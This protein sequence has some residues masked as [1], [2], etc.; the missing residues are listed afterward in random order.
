MRPVPLPSEPSRRACAAPYLIA[1]S[2]AAAWVLGGVAVGGLGYSVYDAAVNQ[3]D[4]W[5]ATYRAL[6]AAAITVG[7]SRTTAINQAY[8]AMAAAA[9]RQ[10]APYLI[11]SEMRLQALLF[12]HRPGST[13]PSGPPA[14]IASAAKSAPL[15]LPAP[16]VVPNASGVIRSFVQESDQVYYRVFSGSQQG[17]FLTSVPPRSSAFAR[18]ALALPPSN[19]ASFIPRSPGARW[20]ALAAIKSTAGFWWSR[21]R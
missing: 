1:A 6:T 3:G 5:L 8:Q 11:A 10:L 16:S 20:H 2:P 17:S 4:P 21:R 12:P 18:E 14:L 7:F 19:Q 9:Q 13:I 15:A